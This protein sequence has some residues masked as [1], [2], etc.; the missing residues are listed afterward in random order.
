MQNGERFVRE[1]VVM[2]KFLHNAAF[3]MMGLVL[4]AGTVVSLMY[5]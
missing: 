3:V 5:A 4:I 2:Q 1:G